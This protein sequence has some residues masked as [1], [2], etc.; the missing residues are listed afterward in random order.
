MPAEEVI[1]GVL[2]IRIQSLGQRMTGLHADRAHPF[3]PT[4]PDPASR[5]ALRRLLARERP[6]VVHSHSWLQ[7]SYF[8]LYHPRRG[9]RTW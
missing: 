5:P 4:A 9:P 1:N 3:H 6:D 7:Y 2:V 8:P